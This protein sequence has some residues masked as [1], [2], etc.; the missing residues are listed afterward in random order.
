MAFKRATEAMEDGILIIDNDNQIIAITPR[1]E[2]YLGINQ[3]QDFGSNI[4]NHIRHPSFAEYLLSGSLNETIIVEDLSLDKKALEFKLIPFDSN[5]KIVLCRDVTKLRKLEIEKKDFVASASHELKTPLTVINGY[6]ETVTE[7]DV[8]K[9]EKKRMLVEMTVQTKLMT[10]LIDDLLL[11]SKLEKVKP[12]NDAEQVNVS[13]MVNELSELS[14]KIDKNNHLIKFDIE[15]NIFITC[16]GEQLRSAFWNLI[17]NA[18]IYTK[19][20]G[21][22]TVRWLKTKEDEAVFEVR[23]DGPGIEAHHIDKLTDRFYRVDSARSRER[24]GTGLGLSIVNEIVQRHGAFLKIES[25]PNVGSNFIIFFPSLTTDVS[26]K[27][28]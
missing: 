23:D 19:K 22:I 14:N 8:S 10:N 6:L 26:K 17:N 24:G 1:A 25:Q 16:C 11:F 5:Q 4:L 2:G 7:M 15:K 12:S 3:K 13:L 28:K 27:V 9:A 21:K 20:G 18:I